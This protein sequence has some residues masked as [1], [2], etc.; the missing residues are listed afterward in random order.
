MEVDEIDWLTAE[1]D[2]ALATLEKDP[3]E[4][5]LWG[6]FRLEGFRIDEI[7]MLL[8]SDVGEQEITVFKN[9]P[10]P[11]ERVCGKTPAAKRD[12]V[13]AAK[14]H[15]IDVR[16]RAYRDEQ[17]PSND[18]SAR[19]IRTRSGKITPQYIN[20]ILK[21][22]AARAGVRVHKDEN[23]RP[24]ALDKAGHNVSAIKSH[25]LRKTFGADLLNPGVP[26]DVVSEQLGHAHVGVTK[27]A[28][29]RLT[30]KT[31]RTAI[32]AAID[33]GAG[34]TTHAISALQVRVEA[35]TGGAHVD[36]EQVSVTSRSSRRRFAAFARASNSPRSRLIGHRIEGDELSGQSTPF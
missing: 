31:Q 24:I 30:M 27:K 35:V 36:R 33:Q 1:E 18:P 17:Y 19:Y 3:L 15:E 29:A 32:Y 22:I 8:D 25:T 12:V 28:Y 21:A 11:H 16:Y 20:R 7:A 2:A 5:V 10:S 13:M 26:M 34:T 9:R 14:M 23:G 6:L 4:E